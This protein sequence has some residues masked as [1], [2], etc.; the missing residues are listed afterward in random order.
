MIS[1]GCSIARYNI[2]DEY[3]DNTSIAHW[4]NITGVIAYIF[5]NYIVCRV[6]INFNK[7][8]RD[9]YQKHHKSLQNLNIGIGVFVFLIGFYRW[10]QDKFRYIRLYFTTSTLIQTLVYIKTGLAHYRG[11]IY[12]SNRFNNYSLDKMSIDRL[13]LLC[14]AANIAYMVAAYTGYIIL[15]YPAT[16]MTFSVMVGM[17]TCF[18]EMNCAV[19]ESTMGGTLLTNEQLNPHLFLKHKESPST[20][21]PN[22]PSLPPPTPF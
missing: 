4:S 20:S 9:K 14:I 12:L 10:E 5:F 2:N 15:Q 11:E 19:R 22:T 13:F 6:L 3:S 8:M 1:C 17:V 7:D 21:P 16:G 18:G